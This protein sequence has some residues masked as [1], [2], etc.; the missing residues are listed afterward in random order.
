MSNIFTCPANYSESDDAFNSMK[1]ICSKQSNPGIGEKQWEIFRRTGNIQDLNNFK[2][3]FQ[4]SSTYPIQTL[5]EEVKALA[6]RVAACST[7]YKF[8]TPHFSI[9]LIGATV[10]LFR[11]SG[12]FLKIVYVISYLIILRLIVFLSF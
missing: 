5:K 4:D 8:R 10:D 7:E 12:V 2:Q 6:C 1:N 9:N 11:S 3:V